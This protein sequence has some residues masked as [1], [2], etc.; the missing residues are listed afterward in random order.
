[1]SVND[2][3]CRQ[4]DSGAGTFEEKMPTG[5]LFGSSPQGAQSAMQR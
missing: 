4:R 3:L 1:M 5:D 2:H